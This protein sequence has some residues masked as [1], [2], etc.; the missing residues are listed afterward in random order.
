MGGFGSYGLLIG[1]MW[2]IDT[3]ELSEA[4]ADGI[5]IRRYP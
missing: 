5:Y 1:P 4:V 2:F 3:Y